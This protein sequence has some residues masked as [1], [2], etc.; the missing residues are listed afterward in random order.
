MIRQNLTAYPAAGSLGQTIGEHL[1]SPNAARQ[2][3]LSG[4]DVVLHI[5]LHVATMT[6]TVQH[7]K[8]PIL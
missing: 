6:P 8:A 4:S 2:E 3:M 1:L 5:V 7:G